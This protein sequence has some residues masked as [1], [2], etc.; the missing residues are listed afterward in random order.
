M[1]VSTCMTCDKTS[2]N[3]YFN[4]PPKMA[5]GRNFTDYRPRCS[6]NT[7]DAKA[8]LNSYAYRQYMINNAERLMTNNILRV[9]KENSCGPCVEPYNQG[10]MMPE[11]TMVACDKNTCSFS[12]NNVN[13]LGVGRN[14]GSTPERAAIQR[15]FIE[16]K[17]LLNKEMTNNINCCSKASDDID[18]Y[19]IS[20]NDNNSS[21]RYAMP[22]GGAPFTGTS[23]TNGQ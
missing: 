3:R 17:E 9:T 1:S 10:T 19:S 15:E 12:A 20:P 16:S 11:Q 5:D 22:G 7:D 18:Q 8:P 13:G 14:Y 23:R 21:G 6:A 4:C 2:E